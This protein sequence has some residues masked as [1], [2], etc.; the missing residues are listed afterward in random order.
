MPVLC[1]LSVIAWLVLGSQDRTAQTDMLAMVI[2]LPIISLYAAA[3]LGFAHLARRRQ[4][5]RL[6]DEEQKELW[7]GVMEAK[8]GPLLIYFTDTFIWLASSIGFV[9]LFFHSL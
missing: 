2:Q 5:K 1:A 8:P 6:D 9:F 7:K 3:A 4:R